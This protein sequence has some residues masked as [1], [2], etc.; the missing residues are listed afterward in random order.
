MINGTAKKCKHLPSW[1]RW[2]RKMIYCSSGAESNMPNQTTK[3]QIFF[4]SCV[5]ILA[6]VARNHHDT[7]LRNRATSSVEE[8][9]RMLTSN[10]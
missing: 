4:F 3:S 7:I 6:I 9:I 5:M 1:E 2:L 8:S 10:I